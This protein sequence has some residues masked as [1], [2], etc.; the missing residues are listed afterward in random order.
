MAIAVEILRN[1]VE[2]VGATPYYYNGV[3]V[4]GASLTV[5]VWRTSD[6]K[7]LDFA[8]STFKTSPGTATHAVAETPAASGN[9][10]YAL[11]TSTFVNP[12]AAGVLETYFYLIQD[13]TNSRVLDGA[14]GEIRVRAS[15]AISRSVNLTTV[16]TATAQAGAS[17]SVTLDASASATDNLYR[18]STVVIT[19][20]TGA[21][22]V[23]AILDYVGSTKVATVA[24]GWVTNPDSTSVFAVIQQAMPQIVDSGLAQ[25]GAASTIT[26][27]AGSSATTD[28]YV[29]GEV[30]I[31]AGTGAGQNRVVSAYNGGTKVATVASAWATNPDATSVYVLLPIGRTIAVAVLDKTGYSLTGGEETNIANA[32]LG[33]VVP[34]AFAAGTLG[35]VIGSNVL[36][37]NASTT[38]TAQA[39]TSN[40]I[41][42]AAG[43]SATDNLYRYSNVFITGGTG[44]GQCNAI[45]NYVGSTKVAA[46]SRNWVTTPDATSTYAVLPS[47]QALL[48]TTGLL[49]AGTSTTA[50]LAATA[51]AT[52]SFYNDN[53]IRVSG[54]TG[55]GQVRQIQ[56]YVGATKIATLYEAWSTIPDATSGYEILPF[57]RARMS[58]TLSGA[59]TS[60]SFAADAV[61]SSAVSAGAVTKIQSGLALTTDVTSA[62]TTINAHTDAGFTTL[63]SHGDSAWATAI[64]FA[65]SGALATA[66]TGI[67]STNST[68]TAIQGAGWTGGTDDLHSLRTFTGTLATASALSTAQSTLNT[69]NA[70]VSSL[71]VPL[72]TSGTAAA[73]WNALTASYVAANSFGALLGAY[74]AAPSAVTISAA[75]VDQ[76]LAGHTTAGSVGASLVLLDAAVSS[77]STLTQ[78]QILSDATPFPGARLDAAISSRASAAQAAELIGA[79]VA[80]A[81][82]ASAGSTSTVVNSTATQPDAFYAGMVLVCVHSS[83]TAARRIASYANTSGA[84]TLDTALPFTP[85]AADQLYVIAAPSSLTASQVE[86]A[87]WDATAASHV[88]GGSMGALEG[89]LTRLDAAVSSRAIPG[90]LMG[91]VANAITSAKINAGA[92]TSTAFAANAITSTTLAAS[93]ITAFQ[94]AILSDATPFAGGA[95]AAIQGAGF[96]AGDDLHNLRVAV[97]AIPT[98]AAPSA[99]TNA[100]ATWNALTSSFV[101]AG[102]FGA[103][104]G[105]NINATI[106]SRSTPA[107]VTASTAAVNAHTDTATGPLATSAALATLSTH[108]DA[109]WSAVATWNYDVSTFGTH[110]QIGLAG[111]SLYGLKVLGFNRLVE[112]AGN[113]GSVTLYRDGGVLIYATVQLRDASGGAVTSAAGEPAQRTEAA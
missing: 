75:V 47:T 57:G 18:Y 91:L 4:T 6:G 95:I 62:T 86:N 85:S 63:T 20:G 97:N 53:L 49:Q 73:V 36:A 78:N 8:D 38:G 100:A 10:Y 17:T 26:L 22:Q 110:A 96:G 21:G 16:R 31:L 72:T 83:G 98:S 48:V 77:R 94:S 14:S 70:T 99:A 54:G 67:T 109:T 103:L 66:Q 76:A 30:V 101:G 24:P 113:P 9:Y 60:S 87:V 112:A 41:T 44:A 58:A 3:L 46:V 111:G 102:S 13:V 34:G 69:I 12:V 33:T 82:T 1:A 28:F 59:I 2:P 32:V 5:K 39:G 35:A 52:D 107:D 81:P 79:L 23:R 74:T 92:L 88:A 55:A 42:L 40:T 27:R 68:L 108:G 7:G 25:A 11:D 105:S 56:S 89:N 90:D 104:L 84:F 61:S 71:P 45:V 51:S 37:P 106:G 93:A 80:A 15:D 50:T 19:S 65:T 64:G 43:A 29:G